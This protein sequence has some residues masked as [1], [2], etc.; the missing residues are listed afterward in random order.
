MGKRG[1]RKK[2]NWDKESEALD[3]T[4]KSN[5]PK[6]NSKLKPFERVKLPPPRDAQEGH[7]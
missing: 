1:K 3:I 2:I 4:S 7:I 6:D 5:A